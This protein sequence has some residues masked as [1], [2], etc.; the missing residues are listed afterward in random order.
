MPGAAPLGAAPVLAEVLQQLGDLAE[1]VEIEQ[2]HL[3]PR[4]LWRSRGLVVRPTQ[5]NGGMGAV[6]QAEDHVG[7][8]ASADADDFAALPPQ[9]VMGVNNG[10]KSRRRLG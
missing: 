10:D 3:T 2:R 5:G 9:G 7:I 1:A 8:S 4:R 6:R